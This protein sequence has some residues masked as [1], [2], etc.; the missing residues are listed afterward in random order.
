MFK[1]DDLLAM[2]M[3]MMIM[4]IVVL[5]QIA[6]Y[7][8]LSLQ[9]GPNGDRSLYDNKVAP[10]VYCCAIILPISYIVGLVFTMKTHSSDIYEEFETQLKEDTRAG[11][12]REHILLE[13]FSGSCDLGLKMI[14]WS[15][16]SVRY[17]CLAENKQQ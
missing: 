12:G 16:C 15:G 5:V 17:K 6:L 1:N 3:L 4:T 2:V 9:F 14:R 11:S 8:Y 13:V 7:F 10:L